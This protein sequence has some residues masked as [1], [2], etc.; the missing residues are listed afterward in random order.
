MDMGMVR[1][2]VIADVIQFVS[3]EE[4]AVGGDLD[5]THSGVTIL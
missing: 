3:C 4:M 5:S 1:E 2:E